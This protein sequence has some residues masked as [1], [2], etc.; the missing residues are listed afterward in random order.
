MP[1]FRLLFVFVALVFASVVPF[2]RAHD[3]FIA[4]IQ[5]EVDA[6][7]LTFRLTFAR[8]VAAHLAGVNEA[9]RLHYAPHRFAADR[10][11]FESAAATLGLLTLDSRPLALLRPTAA[12]LEDEDQDIVFTLVY[13]RPATAARLS[14]SNLWLARLPAAENYAATFVMREGATLLAGPLLV[15]NDNTSVTL[16][17]LAPSPPSLP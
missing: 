3:P 5:A 9:P 13:A 15:S 2:G 12:T 14:F 11:A 7:T 4:G 16:D 10:P 17:L 8:S 6:S 1:R